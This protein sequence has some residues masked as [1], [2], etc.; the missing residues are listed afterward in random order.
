M[1][2]IKKPLLVD[3]SEQ[4]TTLHMNMLNR[5]NKGDYVRVAIGEQQVWVCIKSRNGND[6]VG[7]VRNNCA[8]LKRADMIAFNC[9][10]IMDL[11]IYPT[12]ALKQFL[13]L[14]S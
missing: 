1:T 6:F 10:N 14:T 12:E 8:E 11:W 13:K 7:K 5:L 2:D 9:R 4:P 3:F